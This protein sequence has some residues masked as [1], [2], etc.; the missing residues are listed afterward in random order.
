M[1]PKRQKLH[2][3]GRIE[4]RVVRVNDDRLL[5]RL[6]EPLPETMTRPNEKELL[7]RTATQIVRW[8]KGH[9]TPT[10]IE[11]AVTWNSRCLN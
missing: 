4:L 6:R 9:N 2:P 1:T 3:L 7:Y 8:Y 5:C 10:R 11:R